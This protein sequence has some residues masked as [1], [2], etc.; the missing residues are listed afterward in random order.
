MLWSDDNTIIDRW[1]EVF[2]EYPDVG[3]LAFVRTMRD[4]LAA[5]L[6]AL[7]AEPRWE[8][9][10]GYGDAIHI[11]HDGTQIWQWERHQKEDSLVTLSVDYDSK[12]H[13][14]DL[15][16]DVRLCRRDTPAQGGE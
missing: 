8:P 7:R 1:H 6:A 15:P 4:E 5:E 13:T 16:D 11:D 9:V 12:Q 2:G 14:I 3:Q 10:F